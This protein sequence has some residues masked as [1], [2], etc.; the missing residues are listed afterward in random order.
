MACG[1]VEQVL[2]NALYEVLLDSGARVKSGLALSTRRHLS[3]VLVGDRVMVRLA[4][5]DQVRGQITD[6]L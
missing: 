5:L 1:T 2:P 6:K 3:H 4:A